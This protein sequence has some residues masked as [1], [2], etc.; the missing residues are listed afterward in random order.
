MIRKKSYSSYPALDS[1]LNNL[2][3]TENYEYYSSLEIV[4]ELRIQ[5]FPRCDVL[6]KQI[7]L[8]LEKI[9]NKENQAFANFSFYKVCR[10]Y[11]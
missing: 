2:E 3:S 5:K 8:L 1:A 4:D 7:K 9:Y 6:Q 10:S 11:L